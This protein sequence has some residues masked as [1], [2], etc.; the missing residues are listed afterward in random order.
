MISIS[1]WQHLLSRTNFDCCVDHLAVTQIL[2]FKSIPASQRIGRLIE[3]CYNYSLN[4]CYVKD[5]DFI[6]SNFLIRI[7]VD[8]S[9]PHEIISISF[10]VKEQLQ[11]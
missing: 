5:K 10:Y 3:L 4:L 1:L 11:E 2:K 7:A 8:D 9:N 6:L